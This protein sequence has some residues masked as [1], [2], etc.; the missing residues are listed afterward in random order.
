MQRQ[1]E[2]GFFAVLQDPSPFVSTSETENTQPKISTHQDKKANTYLLSKA[3][4]IHSAQRYH[5][6]RHK[7][8]ITGVKEISS[9]YVSL[10]TNT[11]SSWRQ[12]RGRRTFFKIARTLSAALSW[13]KSTTHQMPTIRNNEN[14]LDNKVGTILTRKV[15][16]RHASYTEKAMWSLK[17][18]ANSGA[19]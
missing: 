9:K 8:E 17:M 11:A 19:E 10:T 18:L 4:R 5:I 3:W 16:L 14:L 1:Y 6:K 7:T 2:M 15:P 12:R 13:M